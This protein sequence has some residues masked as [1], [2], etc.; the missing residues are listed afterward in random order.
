[1]RGEIFT[2]SRLL[3]GGEDVTAS[4]LSRNDTACVA[5]RGAV[6]SCSPKEATC[7]RPR[8]SSARR[9]AAAALAVVLGGGERRC[10]RRGAEQ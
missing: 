10:R 2:S 9:A 7:C 1:M 8:P 4:R 6:I 3:L 5:T